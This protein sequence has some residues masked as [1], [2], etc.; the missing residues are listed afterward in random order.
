MELMDMNKPKSELDLIT[1]SR[2]QAHAGDTFF[3]VV[4][5]GIPDGLLVALHLAA[6]RHGKTVNF[7][8]LHKVQHALFLR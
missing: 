5:N 1:V 7:V 4:G 6:A 3:N 2:P 8:V